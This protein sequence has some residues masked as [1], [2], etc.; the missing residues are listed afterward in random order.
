MFLNF[1][2]SN[3]VKFLVNLIIIKIN[4]NRAFTLIE[5][6]SVLTILGIL[7][8]IAVPSVV[9]IIEKVEN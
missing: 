6:I 2:Q 5:V 1:L 4:K 9:G 8:L 3:N 7:L